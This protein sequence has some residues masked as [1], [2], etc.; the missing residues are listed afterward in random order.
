MSIGVS[1]DAILRSKK[2]ILRTAK[3]ILGTIAPNAGSVS[4]LFLDLGK[5]L[6]AATLKFHHKSTTYLFHEAKTDAPLF[7]GHWP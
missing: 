2:P 6:V 1:D 4:T 7:I 3:P 5:A